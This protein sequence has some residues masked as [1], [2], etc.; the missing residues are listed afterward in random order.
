MS[1]QNKTSYANAPSNITIA[2]KAINPLIASD[3]SN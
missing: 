1:Q 3:S 2:T